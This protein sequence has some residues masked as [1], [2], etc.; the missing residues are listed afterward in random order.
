M[1]IRT[2]LRRR[3]PDLRA[4]RLAVALLGAMHGQ[5]RWPHRG[6]LPRRWIAKAGH[7]L[8]GLALGALLMAVALAATGWS[9]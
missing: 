3:E 1:N 2:A 9:P 8:V 7:L 5:D 6:R 4:K